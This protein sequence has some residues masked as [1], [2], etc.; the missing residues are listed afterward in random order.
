MHREIDSSELVRFLPIFFVLL[1]F[2]IAFFSATSVGGRIKFINETTLREVVGNL[3]AESY[4]AGICLFSAQFYI[5]API[6]LTIM[7]FDVCEMS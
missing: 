5:V 3:T 1:W 4:T 6:N 2:W 7:Q